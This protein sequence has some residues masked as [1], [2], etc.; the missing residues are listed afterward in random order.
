M[1]EVGF[2]PGMKERKGVIDVQSGVI[3]RHLLMFLTSLTWLVILIK[4]VAS[5]L[6]RDIAFH[7]LR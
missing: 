2:K 1:K 6:V 7:V 4:V 5:V 3:S